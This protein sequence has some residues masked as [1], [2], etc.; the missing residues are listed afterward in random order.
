M[1]GKSKMILSFSNGEIDSL[2]TDTSELLGEIATESAD[3]GGH[4]SEK[5]FNKPL[6]KSNGKVFDGWE[7][8]QKEISYFS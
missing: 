8:Y 3:S 7:E 5:M 2:E 6:S 4:L 1:S